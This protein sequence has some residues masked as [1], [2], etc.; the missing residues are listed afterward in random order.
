MA[1]TM[2]NKKL[3]EQYLFQYRLAAELI[4]QPYS[5]EAAEE[6]MAFLCG[7]EAL[8]AEPGVQIELIQADDA[9]AESF[10]KASAD[11]QRELQGVSLRCAFGALPWWI[12]IVSR[13]AMLRGQG[14]TLPQIMSSADIWA[15]TE[16]PK[17]RPGE[18][19]IALF[20]DV[21]DGFKRGIRGCAAAIGGLTLKPGGGRY[22]SEESRYWDLSLTALVPGSMSFGL[23]LPRPDASE[24]PD[25]TS[26]QAAEVYMQSLQ[27]LADTESEEALSTLLPTSEER[28][29]VARSFKKMRRALSTRGQVLELQM[30]EG[31]GG[32]GIGARIPAGERRR[33]RRPQERWRHVEVT[34]LMLAVDL[35]NHTVRVMDP[36]TQRP[37]TCSYEDQTLFFSGHIPRNLLEKKV[38]IRGSARETTHEFS[39][40]KA[41]TVELVG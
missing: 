26:F 9:F 6:V 35:I 31:L 40:M 29:Y 1:K 5:L 41:T 30:P 32:L 16:G 4:V 38:R 12:A 11:W 24:H 20:R 34:G 10:A 21:V 39:A 25:P 22:R 13:G 18:I 37:V 15:S 3:T 23:R 28:E 7:R 2:T 14:V 17:G 36:V 19:D 33:M 27:I 8:A